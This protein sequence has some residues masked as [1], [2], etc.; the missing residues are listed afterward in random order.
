MALS[1]EGDALRNTLQTIEL[2]DIGLQSPVDPFTSVLNLKT[3][4]IRFTPAGLWKRQVEQVE[5]IHPI[6]NV[7]EDLFGTSIASRRAMQAPHRTRP[8]APSNELSWT[9]NRFDVTSGQL[10]LAFDG[11]R[12]CRCRS[13]LRPTRTT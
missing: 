3:I 8:A 10:V 7:G 5:I 6:L 11:G 13:H 12:S 1:L 9:I 4:F 2:H